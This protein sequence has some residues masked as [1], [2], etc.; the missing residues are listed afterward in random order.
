MLYIKRGLWTT[1]Q[2]GRPRIVYTLDGELNCVGRRDDQVK[3]NNVRINPSDAESSI[4]RATKRRIVVTLATDLSIS[5]ASDSTLV[6][7]V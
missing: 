1:I 5:S 3:L 4:Q 7:F 6:V 2:H